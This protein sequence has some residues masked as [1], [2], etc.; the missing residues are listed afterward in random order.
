MSIMGKY[1]NISPCRLGGGGP[2]IQEQQMEHS[3]K[4]DTIEMC[5]LKRSDEALG[6]WAI[7]SGFASSLLKT[8]PGSGRFFSKVKAQ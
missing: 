7:N 8:V 4:M 2:S 3:S 5:N 1:N 6:Q